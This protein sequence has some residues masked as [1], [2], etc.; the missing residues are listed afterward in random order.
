MRNGGVDEGEEGQRP[1]DY[2]LANKDLL[3]RLNE[4]IEYLYSEY[5]Y[6]YVCIYIFLFCLIFVN[7]LRREG[8]A[9]WR[10][11]RGRGGAAVG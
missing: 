11:G 5:I 8:C 9:E 3:Y 2:Y 4:Y 7:C 6:L 1:G 10:S